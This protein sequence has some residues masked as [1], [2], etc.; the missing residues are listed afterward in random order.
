MK[1]PP[2]PF[3]AAELEVEDRSIRMLRLQSSLFLLFL[4][5]LVGGLFGILIFLFPEIP[6][7]TNQR[8]PIPLSLIMLVG[9]LVGSTIALKILRGHRRTLLLSCDG[10]LAGW[11]GVTASFLLAFMASIGTHVERHNAAKS[12]LHHYSAEL[13]HK[14]EM[15]VQLF[16]RVAQRWAAL[17]FNV[18]RGLTD[19][20]AHWYFRDSP[21]LR[22]LLVL[23]EDGTQP[24]RRGKKA[25]DLF[26]LIEKVN[27]QEVSRWI[28]QTRAAGLTSAWHFPD[29]SQPSIAMLMITPAHPTKTSFITVLDLE[30]ML[31]PDAR[32]AHRDFGISI[33]HGES[34]L[35][36]EPH[37]GQFDVY[38]RIATDIPNSPRFYLVAT[39]GPVD[40]LSVAGS[41]PFVLLV[42]GLMTSYLLVMGRSLL[43]IQQEQ[44]AALSLSAQQFRSLFSKSPEPVFAFDC[45]GTYQAV[46]PVARGIAGLSVRDMGVVR[47]HDILTPDTITAHD[48]KTFDTAFG[49]AVAGKPQQFDV[50]FVNAQ[51]RLHDYEIAFVPIVVN[52]AVTGVF[53]IVKDITDRVS[54]QENQR[55]LQKSLESSDNA[56]VVVD[57][58]DEQLPVIFINPA[59]SRMTGYEPH[60]MRSSPIQRLVGPETESTDI[61]VI[62][63]AI[64]SGAPASLTLK[65]YRKNGAP[66]WTQLSLAPVKDEAGAVTHFAAL[67]NDIS[68]KKEQENRLA[69]QATHDVLTGLANR[70][71]FE[72]RLGHDFE[73]ARRNK[74]MLAVMFIDLDEFKPINDTLGHKVGDALLVSIARALESATRPTDTL[75]RFGGD[76]F[77]LL[78][79]DLDDVSEAEDVASRILNTLARPHQVGNH[80]LYISASIGI[81]LQDEA[82]SSPEKLIQQADMAMYKAKQQ[83]RDTF[84][85][86]TGDL[87][88]KLSKR[89]TLRNDLQEAIRNE[90]LYLNYQPQV[91]QNGRFCGLEALVRWKHP[92]K[93]FISPAD[94]IPVAEETGQIVHLGR[95]ITTKAC[96]DAKLLLDMELL[97][98]RMS[99]NLSPLQFHRPRF[100][101]TLQ[102]VLTKTG[103]P[104]DCLEL[105]LTE[106]IL[107]RDSQGA[108]EILRALNDM[109]VTTSIDDFGTG[110]SSFSYLK[111]LPVHSIKVDKSFVDNLVTNPKDA[112]VCKGVIT[113]AREMGLNVVAEGVET[114]EQFDILKQYDCGVYQGYLFARP[115]DLEDLLPWIHARIGIAGEARV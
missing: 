51:R 59:F 31:K 17:D 12:T 45:L 33:E 19:A 107:M 53:G 62:R 29:L 34:A 67:M 43:T 14:M 114:R 83:G 96:Q 95:W 23:A 93:G 69:Y 79:P 36:R 37:H 97:R 52:G 73:L 68:E 9:G 42:F 78:V 35:S 111:D 30:K 88:S 18:R 11:L 47:Y 41:L 60:E 4:S 82:M 76:E 100:L 70:A 46:N 94:F 99:V 8:I 98:G 25:E 48:F 40:L 27:D 71:L 105:E 103:L 24:W 74:Q 21:A 86:Y 90:Q 57:A 81:A 108:I 77:V 65:C 72:D 80:E 113:M 55:V 16:S 50:R 84:E 2:S 49:K 22:A 91:D 7:P 101:S 63:I 61:E 56:V 87:D 44:A 110:Y 1:S 112:A 13:N 115:M 26:W 32:S 3:I 64:T 28:D 89:V 75:A 5:V 15:T 10:I 58:R 109:G 54:A 66:F 38:E 6:L 102:S 104:A 39:S 92:I 85:V 106:G 20:G